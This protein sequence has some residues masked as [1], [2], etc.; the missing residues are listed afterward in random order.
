MALPDATLIFLKSHIELPM[1]PVLD[2]PMT[3]Y[4]FG[5]APGAP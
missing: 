3:A 4:R 1:Q 5:K 2:T